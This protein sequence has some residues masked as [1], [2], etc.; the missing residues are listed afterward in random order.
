MQIS[1]QFIII[2]FSFIGQHKAG[3]PGYDTDEFPAPPGGLYGSK[4]GQPGEPANQK[5]QQPYGGRGVVG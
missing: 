1:H 4:Y 3:G 5:D 2:F